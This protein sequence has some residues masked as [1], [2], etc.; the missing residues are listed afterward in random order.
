MSHEIIKEKED[1]YFTEALKTLR[2][3]IQFSGEN[4]KTIAITSTIPG[5]G[6]SEIS[7]HLARTFAEAGKNTLLID[8]DIRLSNMVKR[9]R[10][11][12]EIKGLS[13]YL[14]GMATYNEVIQK[15]S[16]PGFYMLFTGRHVPNPSELLSSDRFTDLLDQ[17]KQRF[18]VIILDTPPITSVIDGAIVAS[19]CDGTALV[20]AAE[21]I[22]R[23]MAQHAKV[24]LLKSG[25]HVLGVVL[26]K[27]NTS[28]DNYYYSHYGY[29]AYR[30]YTDQ[31]LDK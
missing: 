5:E 31:Y 23:K 25:A 4:I 20:V 26:N 7:I 21:D 15:T 22:S 1:F 11:D 6:K 29:G 13:E 3:N 19:K 10:L 30:K 14:C 8:C 9:F 27:I 24:Q 16:Q 2:A 17:V 12:G 28:K 18:D